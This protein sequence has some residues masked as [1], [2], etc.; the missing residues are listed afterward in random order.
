MDAF[1][2]LIDQ[3]A[4]R[5]PVP[6]RLVKHTLVE[7]FPKADLR[8]WHRPAYIDHGT[9]F[10]QVTVIKRISSGED[11]ALIEGEGLDLYVSIPNRNRSHMIHDLHLRPRDVPMTYEVTDMLPS[12]ITGHDE[13]VAFVVEAVQG[14]VLTHS[15]IEVAA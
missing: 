9:T 7:T 4:P 6:P 11:V 1:L 8:V 14:D 3:D 12:H 13:A 5:N 15:V 10:A 2:A